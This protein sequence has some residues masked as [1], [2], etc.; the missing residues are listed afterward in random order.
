MKCK[1]CGNEVDIGEV[2]C[3]K[4][5]TAIQIVPEYNPLEDELE[6]SVEMPHDQFTE[7]LNR[8][9]EIQEIEKETTIKRKKRIP[10]FLC[11]I[12]LFF[13]V[14]G[15]GIGITMYLR[16]QEEHSFDYQY[17]QGMFYE[18]KN[19]YDKAL[20]YYIEA[21][22][23]DKWNTDVRLRAAGVYEKLGN[24]DR[25]QELLLEVVNIKPTVESYKKLMEVC[26]VSGNTELMNRVLKETQG[27][28]IGDALSEYQTAT[29]SADIP[30]GEYHD[31]LTIHLIASEEEAMIYYTLDGS[32]PTKQ[33]TRY[34]EP[35]EIETEGKIVLRAIAYNKAELAGEEWKATYEIKLLKPESPKISP[36]SGTY[37]YGEKI[38]LEAQ[39]GSTAYFTI[40]G[41]IPTKENGYIFTED[42]DMP[43][44]NIIFSAI[45][46]DRYGMV[47]NVAKRNYTCTINRPFGYDA[48]IIK[49]KNYLV[50]IGMMSDLNGNRANDEKISVEFVSLTEVDGQ[51]SYIFTLRRTASGKTTTLNDKLYAVTTQKGD[52]YALNRE[53]EGIY[54][55][56]VEEEPTVEEETT[57]EIAE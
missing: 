25:T 7:E 26:E 31:Y 3:Q 9:E 46:I 52:V 13:L 11:G 49:L 38:T 6:A 37:S 5:G 44:G 22:N 35:L 57:Q 12:F 4:C 28:A 56:I 36:V 27:T 15:I 53:M 30:G 42:I 39:E 34:T 51:E 19:E 40:D 17:Q 2:F 23:Y 1:K 14:S 43:I 54:H 24:Y 45:V 48:A 55:F 41:T 10:I 8:H 29:V 16:Y 21:M 47:S 18:A 32:T 20:N 50:E 33:S